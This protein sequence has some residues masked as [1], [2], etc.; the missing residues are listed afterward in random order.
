MASFSLLRF[1]HISQKIIIGVT[2]IY[3]FF[4]ANALI[5]ILELQKDSKSIVTS[6]EVGQPSIEKLDNFILMAVQSK[7]Y[8]I[9][10][11]HLRTNAGKEDKESLKRLHAEYAEY[12]DNLSR[13]AKK[14]ENRNLVKEMDTVFV[15]FDSL[16]SAQK[17]VMEKLVDEED[18]EDNNQK[19]QAE[20]ALETKIIP[21]SAEVFNKLKFVLS[22]KLEERNELQ[23]NLLSSFDYLQW[24]NIIL[25]S[26]LILVGIGVSY[27]TRRE[28][29]KPIKYINSVFVKLGQGEIPEDKHT[30]FNNDEIGEMASSADK[31]VYHL[32]ATSTFAE[33]I[34]KGNYNANFKPLS[35]K[36]VLGNA[37]VDMRNNLARVAEE[38]KRRRW[39]TEGLV[40]FSDLLKEYNNDLNYLADSV[41]T[42]LVKYINA[43]QGG[44]FVTEN[45]DREMDENEEAYL[46]LVACYAWDRKKYLDQKIYKGDGLVGQVWQE[47]ATICLNEVPEGYVQITSGLGEAN[48]NSILIVPLKL[49]E[50]VFGVI[51][52][53]SFNDFQEYEIKFVE[54]IAESTAST[55]A[56][57]KINERTKRLLEESTLMTEQ[58]KSQEEEMRMNMEELQT[59][60]EHIERTQREMMEKDD[61]I[62]VSSLMIETDKKFTI[63][64]ANELAEI[65]LKYDTNELEGIFIDYV[66]DNLDKA[67]NAKS[68]LLKG[69]KWNSFA[70]LKNKYNEKLFAKA[71]ATSIRDEK[72]VVQKYLF[73]FDDITDA[74]A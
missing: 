55:I 32:R 66:F 25:G 43:N 58:M 73:I 61:L 27:W 33:N 70:D 44:I 62:A 50:E 24:V 51:E 68:V 63:I 54:K 31:L 56:S 49:N 12:K 35:D 29:V 64:N 69:N 11:I 1:R 5:S 28:I 18:Y 47:K 23:N 8:A 6:R 13:L 41:I 16:I 2:V 46:K 10:W 60:Q 21:L 26:V 59:T 52:L 17:Y 3:I 65:K 37:L 30:S 14:W 71:R 34:G 67:E 42:Q 39:E 45:E 48:P 15:K 38:D 74:K 40:K 72:G 20:R 19:F 22:K 7:T 4:I 53:A 57:L 36:D 9:S